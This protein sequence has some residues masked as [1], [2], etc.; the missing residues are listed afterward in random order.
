MSLHLVAPSTDQE[1][2]SI[3]DEVYLT[4][5]R[6]DFQWPTLIEAT[7]SWDRNELVVEPGESQ[8]QVYEFMVGSG[9]QVVSIYTYFHNVKF[10]RI[11]QSAQ[12]WEAGTIYDIVRRV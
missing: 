1:I 6:N 4:R 11:S 7:R 10:R 8:H 12:G 3:Y 9:V 5:E 2:I